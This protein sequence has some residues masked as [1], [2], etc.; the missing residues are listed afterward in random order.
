MSIMFLV[1]FALVLLCILI[2]ARVGGIGL[3][4]FGGLGLAI[5]SFGFDLKPAGL[6]IDV[7]FM[8]MAVVAAAAAMQAAGGLDYMI[9]IATK[10]LR[11]NPKYITFIAPAV[12]WTF[13]VL[14]G[15]GHVAYSVLPVIA[16]VSRQNGVRPERP[17]SMAVIASQFAIVASPIAAAVVAVVH[18]LEPQGITLGSVLS[19]T[20]PATVLGIFVA[21]IF[22][23]KMGKELK[24]D[25][26]YQK[27]LQNPEYVKE[28]HANVNP[29]DIAIKSTAK[30]SVA[31]FLFGALLVVIMGAVPSL[32]P[33]FDG[34]PM[35]MAHTIEIVM[36]SMGALIILFCKPDSTEITKG[37]VF[38]AGMRAVIAI[39][40]IA[41][42]GDTL[43]QAHMGEVKGMVSG[44]VE[45]APWAF[46]FALF[47]LSV[48]VNSQ[49]ATVATLFP[50]AIGLGIPAPI[51][52]G[53]FVAVNGYF[54]VPNYGPIIASIDFDTT[55][56]TRIGKFIFNHSFMLPGLLSMFF[57]LCF[58]LLFANL[59]L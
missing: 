19:V 15:T 21:C 40:G 37:S 34:K 3:G 38:H 47:V 31:L 22:V 6:P 10:I 45:S 39:F 57:S 11:R 4:V 52:I 30:T 28:N 26:H 24:D 23:N 35:G 32:R 18:Y 27:L 17:L 43:M 55:G 7:M 51:L 36:L 25:P 12:T 8:I 58:G 46:A 1:Q 59:F 49:G 44:L 14:A 5:L 2:G 41:W 16:E 50:L 20:M 54:F 48:L 13:T 53:V 56:T 33:V 29:D 42:L 9:K